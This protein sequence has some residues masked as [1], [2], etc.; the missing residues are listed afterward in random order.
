MRSLFSALL[1]FSV[2]V[3]FAQDRKQMSAVRTTRAPAIDGVLDE[4]L[5]H[6]AVP[7][8]DFIQ[9]EPKPGAPSAQKTEVRIV[10]DDLA[11]YVGAVMHDVSADSVL[12][13]LGRR[14]T[15]GNTDLFGLVLDT[16]NDDLNAFGFFVTA[17]GVQIDAKYS[18]EGQD[19][20]W[21]AVWENAVKV[22]DM[23]WVAEIKIPYSAIRFGQKQ[24]QVWG[25]NFLRKI[26]RL[27]ENSFWNRVDPAI[28]GFIL[29]A[30]DLVGITD[31]KPPVRLSVTPYVSAY[32]ENYPYNI[33]GRSN[34]TYSLRGGMDLKYGISDGFTLDMTLV[35]DFGQVQSDNQVLNLSPFEVRYD[36]R[37]PFFL[38][39]TELFN[40]GGL[41]YSRRVGGR[42]MGYFNA[43]YGL[44][45]G[46][47][48]VENPGETQLIN[49][50][51]VSGRTRQKLGIGVFNATTAEMYAIIRDST[52][53]ISRVL[54]QPLTNYNVIVFDQAL[55]N[56]S[57]FDFIN[58]NV[59]R[60]GSAYDANV[61]GTGFRLANKTNMYS[62]G[63]RGVVSQ[64]YFSGFE[65]P[66]L[67]HAYM[68]DFGKSGGNFQWRVD[69]SVESDTYDPNDLGLLFNN[70]TIEGGL[71]LAY[72]IYSP[73]WKVNNLYSSVYVSYVR[74]YN[75][76]AFANF[77][78][79]GE[80]NTTFTK[81]FLSTGIWASIEPV[82]TYD[83]FEPRVKGRF[84][85][86]PKNFTVSNWISS[87]YRKRF[88]LDI[89]TRFRDFSDTNRV[90]LDV[91][92]SPRYRVSNRLSFVY[93]FNRN[94]TLSD[95]GFAAFHG[96]TIIFGRRNVQ[97]VANILNASYTFTN[98]MSL[99][100]RARH[101]W[102]RAKY[103][104]Y[105]ALDE[106][107]MLTPTTFNPNSDI[108]FNAFN[109]DM[110]YTWQFAPGSEMSVVWKDAI[111]TLDAASEIRYLTHVQNTL[112]APQTN[113][114]S[115]RVL[116]YLDY[117]YLA[118]RK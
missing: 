85:T 59:M 71:N 110:V 65:S 2:L 48:I 33:E 52:E 37:R 90:N 36:E 47:E 21:N 13:E 26:R 14:D 88:A 34:N 42:P 79:S 4:E 17:A 77:S 76:D 3:S 108:S 72:N 66:D 27:R 114:F 44:E 10:Y 53:N 61:T 25:V 11:I 5:W 74:S 40:K 30:G 9:R 32:L 75:P 46:S 92:V 7:A 95:V 115:I 23:G 105:H 50:T 18:A 107:G 15:E 89:S 31:V 83:F 38:E 55:K 94:I 16:Y 101:Y 116:Y 22:S 109:I 106:E 39:G 112:H 78:V 70:N 20:N 84:Y 49:A 62:A 68:F 64:K 6:Q 12:R 96:D 113:S 91:N 81:K 104:K 28:Q 69:G 117:L 54:T 51:K 58:T 100:F 63:A 8:T 103:I 56:N 67:G 57:F 102:S 118:R 86:Y 1:L 111:L 19:F 29:Q 93:S 97:T 60:D 45:P 41:F 73:F 87:D 99:T 35:P 82:T 24:D 43:A 80:M 98:R